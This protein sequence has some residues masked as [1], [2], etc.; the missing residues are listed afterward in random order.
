MKLFEIDWDHAIIFARWQHPAIFLS[1]LSFCLQHSFRQFTIFTQHDKTE[2]AT[3]YAVNTSEKH[4][5]M[6]WAI[7]SVISILSGLRRRAFIRRQRI[8]AAKTRMRYSS[9][10]ERLALLT[11]YTVRGLR[12]YFAPVQSFTEWCVM[13][14]VSLPFHFQSDPRSSITSRSSFVTFAVIRSRRSPTHQKLYWCTAIPCSFSPVVQLL[15]A[16]L[17]VGTFVIWHSSI[18]FSHYFDVGLNFNKCI[19]DD[20][21]AAAR[22]SLNCIKNKIK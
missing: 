1:S 21:K 7:S 16:F 4:N 9:Q 15:T 11:L 3:S 8:A 14:F 13:R 10:V 22:Q 12:W 2:N 6:W 18:H 17:D 19:A 5:P 20:T